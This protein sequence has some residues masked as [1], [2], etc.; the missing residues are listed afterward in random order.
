MYLGEGTVCTQP[1]IITRKIKRYQALKRYANY[2]QKVNGMIS[3]DGAVS[4]RNT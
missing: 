2:K 4:R 3:T 1:S